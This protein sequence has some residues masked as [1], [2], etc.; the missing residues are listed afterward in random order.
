MLPPQVQVEE[1]AHAVAEQQQR[2]E[3]LRDRRQ[4]AGQAERPCLGLG[5]G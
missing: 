3:Q 4:R 5:L 2:R 1:A